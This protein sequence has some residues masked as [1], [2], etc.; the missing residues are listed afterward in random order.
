MVKK[1]CETHHLYYNGAVCPLCLSEK[2]NNMLKKYENIATK[3][4]Q[5]T[6]HITDEMLDK[7]KKHFGN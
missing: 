2:H 1:Y 3:K 5:D 7:L 6:E 4:N